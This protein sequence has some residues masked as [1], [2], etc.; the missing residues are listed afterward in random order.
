[1]TKGAGD[2]HTDKELKRAIRKA[3]KRIEKMYREEPHQ[4]IISGAEGDN[5]STAISE[6]EAWLFKRRQSQ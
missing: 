1:M 6:I 4:I 5:P 3:F 2:Q